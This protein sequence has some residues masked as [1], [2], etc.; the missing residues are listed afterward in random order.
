MQIGHKLNFS[1]LVVLMLLTAMVLVSVFF[2][3]RMQVDVRQ[4]AEVEEPLEQAILEMEINVGETARSVQH[5]VRNLE[6]Y[7]LEVITD[8]ERD[9]ERYAKQF[10]RL[11]ETE[12]ERALGRKVTEIY[13]DFKSLGVEITSLAQRR[14]DDIRLFRKDA[15]IIDAL[16]DDKL[17]PAID[18]SSA[19]AM[20]KLEAALS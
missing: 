17:Q 8:S 1:N 9:F 3:H 2:I 13:R 19:G 4:L 15:E 7:S 18:R 12:E 14:V 5:Y 20:T 11:A 6:A 16:I 10:E